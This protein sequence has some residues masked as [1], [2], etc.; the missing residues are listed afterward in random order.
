MTDDRDFLEALLEA[1]GPSSFESRPAAVWR[2]RAEALSEDVRSDSYGNVFTTFNPGGRPRIMMAGHIDE[3]GLIVTH[4]DNEGHL[5]FRGIGGWDPQVLVGQRVRVLGEK[6][7]VIGVVGKKPIHLLSAEERRKILKLSD[8]WIDIGAT[9]QAN[10][11]EHCAPGDVAVIEQPPIRLLNGRLAGRAVDDRMGAYTVLEAAR[12]AAA[13][14]TVAEVVAVASVQEEIGGVGAGPATFAL[15]PDALLVVDLTHATD[16]PGVDE[17][18]EGTSPLRSGPELSVGSYVHQSVL[19]RLKEVARE[20]DIP[21]TIAATPRR[22]GTDADHGAKVRAGVPTAVVSIPSRY[23]HSPNE[24]VD[25]ADVNHVIAL[26]VGFLESL[27][28]DT[29]FRQP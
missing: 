4:A 9:D 3:I 18:Q 11:L 6:G 20:R 19:A 17:K 27:A 21:F 5:S 29:D 8:L 2:R 12:R 23:M 16:M 7:D 1:A 26:L 28:I 10:A 25:D 15:E 13:T 14:G 24:L 22:T